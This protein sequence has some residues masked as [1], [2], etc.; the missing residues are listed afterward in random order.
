MM[1]K[2]IIAKISKIY[3]INIKKKNLYEYKIEVWRKQGI[4]IGKNCHIFSDIYSK[5]PYLIQIDDNTTISGDVLFVTHD[6]SVIKYNPP[7]NGGGTDYFG[8]IIIGKNCFIGM[9]AII[10][11]GVKLA[12]N[13]I[14]GAGSVVTKSFYEPGIIIAGNPAKK[15]GTVIDAK[16]KY[17]NNAIDISK[18]SMDEKR[19]FLL[20]NDDKLISR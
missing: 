9:R 17:L 1:I 20:S 8:K 19:I 12:D 3:N 10:M 6:N 11:Y 5:E 13:I 14:V 7:L 15:I 2:T 16:E 4:I 18:M